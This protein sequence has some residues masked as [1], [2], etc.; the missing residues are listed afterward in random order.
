MNETAF[1]AATRREL[2]DEDEADVEPRCS[3][4]PPPQLLVNARL[5]SPGGAAASKAAC[6]VPGA[7]IPTTPE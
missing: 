2:D 3:P 1:R 7:T 6:A 4:P 5:R